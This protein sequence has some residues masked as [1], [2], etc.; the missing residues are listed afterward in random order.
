MTHVEE[1]LNAGGLA[2]I[3]VSVVAVLIIIGGVIGYIVIKKKRA[4]LQQNL[5]S[6]DKDR[7]GESLM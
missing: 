6:L 7:S 4:R 2:I 5:N 3:I 1:K